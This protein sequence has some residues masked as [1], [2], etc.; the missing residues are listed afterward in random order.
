MSQRHKQPKISREEIRAL[1]GQGEEAVIAF[2]EG[3]LERT[4]QLELRVEGL[5]NQHSK[6]SRNSSKPPSG[7][8]FGKRTGSLRRKSE[9]SSG[10]QAEHPGTTLE[11]S[12]AVDWVVE[13]PVGQC[14]GCNASLADVSVER[15]IVRQVHD[16]PPLQ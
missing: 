12:E 10:G 1:Y 7:D 4:E 14:V 9:R 2:V 3:L 6:D 5:E 8:G 13:H 15:L 16:L 11:W